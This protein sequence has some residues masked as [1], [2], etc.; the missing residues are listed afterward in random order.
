MN[1]ISIMW[2]IGPGVKVFFENERTSLSELCKFGDVVRERD[3]VF[4]GK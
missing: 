1:K 3:M 2:E 4:E